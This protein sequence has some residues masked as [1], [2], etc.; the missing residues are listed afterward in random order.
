M[1]AYDEHGQIKTWG[2]ANKVVAVV[3]LALQAFGIVV[4][5]AHLLAKG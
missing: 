1:N 5:L 4:R 2:V 3:L